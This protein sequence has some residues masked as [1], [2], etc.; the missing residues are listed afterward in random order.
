M[1][2]LIARALLV[3]TLFSGVS[4]AGQDVFTPT[5][6]QANY[7]SASTGS[8]NTMTSASFYQKWA[9]RLMS[10]FHFSL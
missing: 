8:T 5:H 4:F 9:T 7:V 3:L 2:K 6:K 1:K 10:M